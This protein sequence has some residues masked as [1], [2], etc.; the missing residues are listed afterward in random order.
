MGKHGL[1]TPYVSIEPAYVCFKVDVCEPKLMVALSR[2]NVLIIKKRMNE[3]YYN[4][5]R[6]K[7]TRE[8]R[9]K[10]KNLKLNH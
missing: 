8:G 5:R 2:S 10:G 7:S 1:A 6:G 9:A 3:K 4:K